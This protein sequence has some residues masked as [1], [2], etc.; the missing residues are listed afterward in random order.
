[1]PSHQFVTGFSGENSM[2]TKL[3]VQGISVRLGP[4]SLAEQFP[5]YGIRTRSN[6]ERVAALVL[7]G[8]GYEPYL[9][10]YS[11]YR[12]RGGVLVESEHPLF[13]GYVFCRFDA[14]KRL[15]I[16]M[17][18]GVISVLSF[19]KEPVPIPEEE[20]EAV[21]AVL[22]SGLPAEPCPYLREG[23]RVRVTHGSLDGVEG[24]L[25]KKKSQFRMVVSVTML[26]RSISVEID[27]DRLVA[28]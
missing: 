10:L 15:P 16:L 9:P 7:T 26:Q 21:R 28:I 11:H 2:V 5:W 18:T 24:I 19:G 22:R 14:K 27:G 25:V 23:Q 8:K 17:T 12:R 6:H 1:V 20:I 3:S 13:P 4:D